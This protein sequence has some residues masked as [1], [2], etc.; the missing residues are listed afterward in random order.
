MDELAA[1]PLEGRQVSVGRVKGRRQFLFQD[2]RVGFEIERAEIP[3]RIAKHE[4]FEERNR[5][6]AMTVGLR[7]RG[8]NP[9]TPGIRFAAP[10]QP[11]VIPDGRGT[12]RALP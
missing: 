9:A 8:G 6:T 2:G 11:G 3:I 1:A 10:F 12:V 4:V 5:Q 7:R